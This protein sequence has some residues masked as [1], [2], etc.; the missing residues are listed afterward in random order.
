MWGGGEGGGDGLE[1]ERV[2]PST[3]ITQIPILLSQIAGLRTIGDRSETGIGLGLKVC[4]CGGGDGLEM[5]R[6]HPS[7]CITQIPILLSQN[8][9]TRLQD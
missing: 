4:M 1:M 3:C 8:L 2:H 6:V 5:E 9:G 7:T